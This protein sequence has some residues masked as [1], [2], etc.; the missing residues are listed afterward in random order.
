MEEI[1]AQREVDQKAAGEA[2]AGVLLVGLAVLAAAASSRSNNYNN[3]AAAAGGAVIAGAAGAH[4]LGKSFRTSE[5]SKVHRVALE[6]LAESIDA[7]LAPHVVAFE[8][9]T[10]ELSG[11]A[12]QQ[13]SQWRAFLKKI[14]LQERTPEKQL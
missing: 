9:Q 13:F 7:E 11:N 4:F 3:S 12:K 6:E 10:I 14:Y 8:Q 2:V 5:E 1:A